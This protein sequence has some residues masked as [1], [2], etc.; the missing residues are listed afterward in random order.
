LL[1]L[2]GNILQCNRAT[3]DLA[4][5][6]FAD[7]IGRPCW[8]VIHGTAGPI[9]DCPVVRLQQ[10]RHRETLTFPWGDRWLHVIADPMLNEAGELIGAVHLIAD[11]TQIKQGEEKLRKSYG[12]LQ[13][14]LEETVSALAATAES[15]DPY[16]AGHQKRVAQLACTIAREMGLPED[17]IKALRISGQLHDIGKISVPAEILSRPGKINDNEFDLIKAHPEVGYNIVK[18]IHF[19]CA[20][21]EAV[22]QHHERLDGSGYPKG[23]AG[24]EIALEARILGVADVV[25]A[26]ASHRPYR[27]A[28]GIDAAL[29]EITKNK[30]ILYDPQ[31]VD[32]CVRVF[33]EKGFKLNEDQ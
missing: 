21:A 12:K 10:S 4:A 30:G 32:A 1:D 11:I 14:T 17:Q 29:D 2:K 15:R 5:K 31:V 6:P 27:P 20:V 9:H 3:A 13:R 16:I 33:T 18:E 7:I 23:L 22:I 8:E 24:L 25:E 19:P 28:L 26:M